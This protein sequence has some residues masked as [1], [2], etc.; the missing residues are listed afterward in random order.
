MLMQETVPDRRKSETIRW[1]RSEV[2]AAFAL[3]SAI[4]AI[5]NYINNPVHKLETQ[6]ALM[7]Q[8]LDNMK[9]NDLTHIELSQ[10]GF[11]TQLDSMQK[12]EI[13][14]TTQLQE[15]IDTLKK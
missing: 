14:N 11:Q 9:N 3:G 15:I 4:V 2:V 8:Q 1:L 10:Q 5:M 13:V 6:Q 12:Q 7:Q